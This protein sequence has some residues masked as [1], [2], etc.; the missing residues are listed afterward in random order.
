MLDEERIKNRGFKITNYK[1]GDAYVIKEFFPENICR[2]IVSEAHKI[3]KA[4]PNRE[5]KDGMFFSLD[6]LPEGTESER[7]LRAIQIRD[8]K[9]LKN[10]FNSVFHKMRE[11]Q[12][13]FVLD[14]DN[15]NTEEELLPQIIHYPRGGGFFDWHIHP[16]NPV[17]YGLIHKLSKRG[18]NFMKG[19]TEILCSDSDVLKVEEYSDIGDLVLFKYDLKHRVAPCDPDNDLV[20]DIN[21]RWTAILPI[22]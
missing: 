22:Y 14:K 20:F 16:R 17:N 3:M 2:I 10:K 1:S 13:E 18:S 4:L 6:Y 15:L 5:E 7:I 19:A 21:G 12:L 8:F 11:F 9:K